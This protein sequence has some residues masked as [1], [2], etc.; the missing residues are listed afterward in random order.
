M[1]RQALLSLIVLL[2]AA[3]TAA[4]APTPES[5]MGR[6]SA[7]H[8]G[9]Y[10]GDVQALALSPAFANDA[11]IFAGTDGAGVFRST[12]GG[13]SWRD[14]NNGLWAVSYTHLTLPTSDL[15]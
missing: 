2:L 3:A 4:S 15:V 12:D 6:W 13:S 1:S 11:T 5:G 9:M 14:S 10:G 7:G 8:Q